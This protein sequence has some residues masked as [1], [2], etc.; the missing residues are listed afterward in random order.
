MSYKVYV[1]QYLQIIGSLKI[2][3]S[4]LLSIGIYFKI[5]KTNW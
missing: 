2:K 3:Y 5:I 1:F 4:Y